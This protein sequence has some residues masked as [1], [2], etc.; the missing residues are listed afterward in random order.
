MPCSVDEILKD[1]VFL[2]NLAAFESAATKKELGITHII[3]VCPVPVSATEEN[4]HLVIPVADSEYAD[5]LI[6]LPD[7][8][9]F[10]E[11]A[12]ANGGR[13]LIHCV[14]G[15]S[16]STTVLA[17]YLMK[18]RSWTTSAAISFIQ[19]FRPRVQPNYGFVKQLD[20]FLECGYA[21]SPTHPAYKSWK[22]RQKRDVTSFLNQL[23]D[24]VVVVPD[25]LLL[26]SEFPTDP[27]QAKLLLLNLD[28]TH[29][30][31]LTPSASSISSSSSDAT[32]AGVHHR[33]IP[34]SPDGETDALVRALPEACA[35]L[36]DAIAGGG[37]VLVHSLVEARACVVVGAYLMS[38][39]NLSAKSAADI[40]QEALPLFDP[41]PTST[42]TR[43]LALFE[44]QFAAAQCKHK[45]N[46]PT[47]VLSAP[48]SAPQR[49]GDRDEAWRTNS[50]RHYLM[51]ETATGI[52]TLAQQKASIA[53][54]T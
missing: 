38:S 4:N 8:C 54:I 37:T 36:R 43:A 32:P 27:T 28:I 26:C 1:Q 16:R 47:S 44:F 48:V 12:L 19:Q 17:A 21:P 3:S 18:T 35:F 41:P 20:A 51:N 40:I 53:V 10:I 31:S 23:V 52:D 14:M 13:V 49:D 24:C 45:H 15:V 11:D 7:A 25:A 33:H 9:R 29:I 6:H 46:L 34:I 22:R 42:F 39:R 30:L 2:G 50:H 5:L